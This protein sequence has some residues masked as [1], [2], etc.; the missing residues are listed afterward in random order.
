MFRDRR[1][2]SNP[3]LIIFIIV[4]AIAVIFNVLL[5]IPILA[6]NFEPCF[7]GAVGYFYKTDVENMTGRVLESKDAEFNRISATRCYYSGEK[8]TEYDHLDYY[9]FSNGIKARMAFNKLGKTYFDPATVRR[10]ENWIT[11]RVY[12]EPDEYALDYMPDTIYEYYYISGNM[13][14]KASLI[15][16]ASLDADDRHDYREDMKQFDRLI[17]WIPEGVVWHPSYYYSEH[18][19]LDNE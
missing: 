6:K 19:Y 5:V 3:K 10:G 7:P 9:L 2:E 12:F 15:I 17:E 14:A 13:I 8:E 16:P 4:F 11:G 1:H 18:P